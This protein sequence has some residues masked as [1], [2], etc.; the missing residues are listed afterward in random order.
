MSENTESK[1]MKAVLK[2][3]QQKLVDAIKQET[4]SKKSRGTGAIVLETKKSKEYAQQDSTDEYSTDDDY[5]T[6]D[7]YIDIETIMN[8]QNAKITALEE[9]M[10]ELMDD[11]R[12]S[13][14]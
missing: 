8:E 5:T 13:S 3:K 12:Q 9:K 10:A 1:N 2:E 6:D 14:E 4:K 11:K 7:D